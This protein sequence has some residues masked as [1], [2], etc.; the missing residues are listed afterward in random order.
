MLCAAGSELRHKAKLKQD[1][2]IRINP[3]MEIVK[4]THDNQCSTSSWLLKRLSAGL[5]LG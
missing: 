5:V 2:V 1:L 3:H 4:F